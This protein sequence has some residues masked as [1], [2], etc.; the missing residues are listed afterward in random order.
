MILRIEAIVAIVLLLVVLGGVIFVL[1]WL[2]NFNKSTADA[3]SCPPCR[4][5]PEPEP[6]PQW[7]TPGK[8][9]QYAGEFKALGFEEV[10][11]TGEVAFDGTF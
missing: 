9:L 1:R 7:R 10:G 3:P 4:V 6:A 8:V 11:V 2:R 5:Y